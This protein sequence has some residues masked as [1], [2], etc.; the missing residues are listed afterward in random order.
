MMVV[1]AGF[2]DPTPRHPYPHSGRVHLHQR[3]ALSSESPQRQRRVDAADQV[4]TEKGRG[5]LRVSNQHATSSKL[6]R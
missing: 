2:M 1:L 3:S 5:R 4:G 6:F